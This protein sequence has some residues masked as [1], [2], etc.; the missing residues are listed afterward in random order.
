MHKHIALFGKNPAILST[1]QELLAAQGHTASPYRVTD[2]NANLRDITETFLGKH[3]DLIVL[4][5]GLSD[6]QK[7][8]IQKTMTDLSSDVIPLKASAPIPHMI[9]EQIAAALANKQPLP[10]T[11]T[12]DARSKIMRVTVPTLQT[13]GTVTCY[14]ITSQTDITSDKQSIYTGVLETNAY[15]FNIPAAATSHWSFATI[16]TNKYFAVIP[17]AP[18]T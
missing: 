6:E 10:V 14:W 15:A 4:G 2:T 1:V 9:V 8:L 11:P 17:I 18:R 13:S 5:A 7:T 3:I 12:Y 16:N